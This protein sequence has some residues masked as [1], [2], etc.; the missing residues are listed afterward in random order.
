MN[1]PD[2]KEILLAIDEGIYVVDQTRTIIFWNKGA[3]K[4]TGYSAEDVIGHKCADNILCH[5]TPQG[6][7]LCTGN[8]PLLST[9]K[10][11]IVTESAVFLHHKKGHRLPVTV[12]TYPLKNGN[13]KTTGAV[14]LFSL[15]SS[16]KETLKNFE[17]MHEAALY[18]PMTDIG[19]RRFG[20]ATLSNLHQDKQASY[21]VLF[22]DI[23]HFK[24]V[25]DTWGHSTG[26]DVLRMV[27]Q[28]LNSGLRK[29]D[30]VF[31][32]GGEEFLVVL[33]N[34]SLKQLKLVGERLRILIE[35]SWLEQSNTLIK[36]TASFGGAIAHHD[37]EI[38]SVLKRADEQMYLSKRNGRNMV[39]IDD[40]DRNSYR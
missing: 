22:V 24:R 32:W 36:V 8:C 37:E 19:N 35:N 39:S 30:M 9:L 7:N 28:S 17:A 23:D 10:D 20:E 3:E 38:E 1:Q 4:L 25:N 27:A 14:E 34:G 11:D 29:D 6:T 21:G 15:A 12:K 5:I 33:P 18:D 40:D 31:R 2:P 26:D 16:H 13:G